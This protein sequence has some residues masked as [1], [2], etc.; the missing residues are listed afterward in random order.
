MNIKKKVI[1]LCTTNS[2]RSQIA[3]AFLKKYAG[4]KFEVYSAGLE[5]SD[6]NYYTKKVMDEIGFDISGHKSKALSS[7]L[8]QAHFGYLITVCEKAEARCPVFPGVSVRLYWPFEDPAAFVG[9]E[10]EKIEKFRYVRDEIDKKIKSW[11]S[12]NDK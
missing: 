4:N 5:P 8:G 2:A 12:E 11:L 6:I 3:E 10:E 1:F 9:S 7:F